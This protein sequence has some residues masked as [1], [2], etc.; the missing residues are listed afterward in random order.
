M[1]NTGISQ[2]NTSRRGGKIMNF[3]Q[4]M[5][6]LAVARHRNIS[7]AAASL[8]I[9]QPALSLQIKKLE[10]ELGVPLFKRE[11]QGVQLT[12]Q[13]ELF[14]QRAQA[15]EQAW[16]QLQDAMSETRKRV[17]KHLRIGIG[18]RVYTNNLFDP[19]MRFFDRHPE[20]N[21]T[22]VTEASGDF[23]QGLE[24]GALDLALDRLPA[25]GTRGKSSR[26]YVSE[27]I[28][29]R[30]CVL[31]SQDDPLAKLDAVDFSRLEGRTIITGLENSEEDKMA[32][33]TFSSYGVSLNKI[34]RSDGIETIMMLVEKGKGI[35]LGPGSFQS[36][37]GIRAIPLLPE[38][39]LSMNFICLRERMQDP[40]LRMLRDYLS[41]ICRGPD[42]QSESPP[43]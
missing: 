15:V 25:A 27:L 41:G 9:S 4:M 5:Y 35:T 22:L 37:F 10:E 8:F 30:Q 16:Y 6:A 33:H 38:S 34:Y 43:E 17:R 32:L 1:Y 11:P 19:L 42:R 31:T 26:L 2:A 23:V 29:E 7:R 21:V 3:T 24:S 18:T 28:R 13:G 40:D 39:Y 20:M 14:Y 36:Y 12:S